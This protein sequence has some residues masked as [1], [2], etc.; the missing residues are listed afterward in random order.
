MPDT[1]SDL[2]WELHEWEVDHVGGSMELK[3]VEI[4]LEFVS[5]EAWLPSKDEDLHF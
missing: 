4:S 2:R 5:S 3:K 1:D